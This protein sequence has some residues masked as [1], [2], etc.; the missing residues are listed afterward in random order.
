ML[1]YPSDV[2]AGLALGAERASICLIAAEF[3]RRAGG[4]R[5]SDT[6]LKYAQFSLVGASNA[7]VDLGTLN[8]LLL[9]LPTQSPATLVLYNLLALVLANANSYVWNSMWTF[10]HH[11]RH[12]ARQVGMFA[13]QAALGIGVGSLVLWLVA[14]GL[15]SYEGLSPLVA[16]NAAKLVSMA[17]GSTTSFVILRFFVFRHKDELDQKDPSPAPGTLPR[18]SSEGALD[19]LTTTLAT[20]VTRKRPRVNRPIAEQ[21]ET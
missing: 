8:L 11:A 3:F 16:G 14:R 15:V 2:P 17:V 19:P 7:L 5:L 12:D 4:G 18:V 6:G 9:A 10:R 20:R 21:P 1:D 13:A